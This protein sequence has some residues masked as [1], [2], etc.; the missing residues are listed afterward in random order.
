MSIISLL[1]KWKL[2]Q[3]MADRKVTNKVLAESIGVH[4]NTISRWKAANKMPKID[5]DEIEQI[6]KAL[7]CGVAE[8]I[9]LP[10]GETCK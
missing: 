10:E 1:L 9:Q 4:A 3:L 8:L 2:R 6:C 7:G 5:G